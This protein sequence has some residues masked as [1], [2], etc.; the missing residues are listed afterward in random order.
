MGLMI[1]PGKEIRFREWL[2]GQKKTVEVDAHAEW[3]AEESWNAALA[4][5]ATALAN[6]GVT[7]YTTHKTIQ[8]CE[9]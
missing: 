8:R 5:A 1:Q 6:A 7:G 3:L 4:L 9:T 2:D